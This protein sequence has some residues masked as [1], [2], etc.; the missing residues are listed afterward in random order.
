M[1][2]TNLF[3][4]LIL[5]GPCVMAQGFELGTNFNLSQPVGMMSKNMNNAFG[6]TLEAS[7]IFNP[8]FT[9]GVE[10]AFGSYGYQSTRQQ[11]TF[12]DGSVTET[13]VNVSNNMT[14]AFVTGKHFLL[15][16]KKL[17]PYL[18]GKAGWTWFTTS[19]TIEDPE[20]EYSCHPIESDILSRD[21]TYTVSGGA[22]LRIDL[23]SIFKNTEEGRFY[24]DISVH[25]T[26]GGIVR[27]MNV[28]KSPH[29]NAPDQDVMAR[30]INTQT[31]VIH[32][33][34][35]G[36]VYSSVMNMMDYRIGIIMRPPVR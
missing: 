32:E 23:Q 34:H 1:K 24:F 12:D 2:I 31:Q 36:Y 17:K 19:L 21:N 20:D 11:Y 14:S 7:K 9:L 8:S 6:V 26:H 25:G 35:V 15:K 27:Y 29:M 33:H 18:S 5:G 4:I 30:F 3:L 10:M 22:G 28:R 16:D 13:D